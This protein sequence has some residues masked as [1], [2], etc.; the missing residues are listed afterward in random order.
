MPE[1]EEQDEKGVSEVWQNE[2]TFLRALET[3]IQK[4]DAFVLGAAAELID[5]ALEANATRLDIV[6][7]EYS[8]MLSFLDN[9]DGMGRFELRRLV[10]MGGS[11]K[12]KANYGYGF[13][14]GAMR[15]GKDALIL[16]QHYECA[17]TKDQK[18][19][20]DWTCKCDAQQRKP[21]RSMVFLSQKLC[22]ADTSRPDKLLKVPM[23]FWRGDGKAITK[24]NKEEELPCD[25][26]ADIEDFGVKSILKEVYEFSYLHSF[27][28]IQSEFKKLS[29]ASGK[30]G[31]SKPSSSSFNTGTLVLISRLPSE[32]E[33]QHLC[34]G[35]VDGDDIVVEGSDDDVKFQRLDRYKKFAEGADIPCDYSLR[36][37]CEVL[38]DQQDN[39]HSMAICIQG[40][41][42]KQWTVADMCKPGVMHAYG[43][44]VSSKSGKEK[45]SLTLHLGFSRG[46]FESDV[47][48]IF[49]YFDKEEHAYP[50]RLIIP[51]N[52]V[53]PDSELTNEVGMTDGM[54]GKLVVARSGMRPDNGKQKFHSKDCMLAP[55]IVEAVQYKISEFYEGAYQSERRA[56]EAEQEQ[57]KEQGCSLGAVVWARW[58]PN[59]AE[60][61]PAEVLNRW[62]REVMRYVD[63]KVLMMES[64]EG[65]GRGKKDAFPRLPE[66]GNR[67]VRFLVEKTHVWCRA[68]DVV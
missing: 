10:L 18:S 46:A 41:P 40:K 52:R 63:E 57:W 59:R 13:K 12:Q 14:N 55:A 15:L 32:E 60:R 27:K 6:L 38:F 54:V 51:Y 7:D 53:Y 58:G 37:Y 5:N 26:S 19:G 24:E 33:S 66:P 23:I 22:E 44:T 1:E 42:V 39:R 62:D 64:E 21:L 50:P 9:G 16:T 29:E 47:C 61:S 45:Q 48:G 3:P 34:V 35:G 36:A 30:D 4:H 28:A 17:C 43:L 11:Y 25:I 31:K 65:G 20:R 56:Y 68:E 49:V 67:L 2:C 8:A